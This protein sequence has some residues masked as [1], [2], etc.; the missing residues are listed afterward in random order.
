VLA[1]A[2][3]KRERAANRV[4]ARARAQQN[5]AP[6][7]LQWLEQQFASLGRSMSAQP[8]RRPRRTAAR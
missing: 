1:S 8:Q 4:G 7:P 6:A 2:P 3:A 5:A